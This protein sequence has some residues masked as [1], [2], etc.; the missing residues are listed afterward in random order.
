[1]KSPKIIVALGVSHR[2][3]DLAALWLRWVNF[4]CTQTDGDNR[5]NVLLIVHTK[6]AA[7]KMALVTSSLV[8]VCTGEFLTAV[9]ECPDE[10]ES[11]YPKSASHLFLRTLEI[12]EARWPGAAVFWAEPDTVPMRPTWF[13]EIAAEYESCGR[14]FLGMKVGTQFPHLSGNAVYPG[15]WREVAPSIANVLNAPDYRMWGPGKGQPW[16][17]Y[18]RGETTPQMAES[19]IMF[20][21]WKER[22]PRPTRLKDI[23][24]RAAFFHQ[25]KA[26]ALIREIAASRYPEFMAELVEPRRFFLMNGHPS[27]LRAKGLKIPFTFTK[28]T[29]AGHRSA[30]CSDELDDGQASSLAALVGQL[31]IREISEAEFLKITGRTARTL[32]E[33]K[34]RSLVRAPAPAE[35]R[36]SV[37]VML[38]R[39]G[40]ICNILP[41]LKA[42]ADAGRRPTLVVSQD[43]ADIL[44]GVSYVDRIVWDGGYDRLPDALRWLRREKGIT[45]AIVCQFHRNPYDKG[46]LTD[47][48]QKEV[49]RLAGRLG[50]FEGRGT[51]VFDNRDAGRESEF[52]KMWAPV[53]KP[54]ILVGLESISSP[55]ASSRAVFSEIVHAFQATHEIVDLS[56]VHAPR[57][58][59][60]I[61]LYEKAAV[62]VSTDTI[63]LHL[64]RG[65]DT[66]VIA[67]INDGWRGS[68]PNS[69]A[70]SVIRYNA[71]TPEKVVEAIRAAATSPL[72]SVRELATI[73]QKGREVFGPKIYHVVDIF[74]GDGLKK[75]QATWP[76]AY[77]EGITPVP[78]H[79]Y[80]RDA[81][82]EL[83]DPRG[84]PFLKDILWTGI[85]ADSTDRGED[86]ILWTNSDIGLA[87]GLAAL[88][89]D[90]VGKHGA[91]S[92]RRTESDGDG[93]PGRDLFA[94]TVDWLHA[95][96]DEIPDYVIGAPV[97]DLGLVAIIRKFHELPFTLAMMDDDLHPAEMHPGF[98]LHESHEPAWKLPN[99]D[100]IPSV[101]HNKKLFREWAKKH[102][103]EIRFSKGGNL[104]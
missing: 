68:V 72:I 51:L 70:T 59:D 13:K 79:G 23:P 32:P 81:K 7:E 73:V 27:R 15:N 75:A 30:V 61:A 57:V 98:A 33:P 78:I 67:I 26:G 95:H 2:D 34:I 39:F 71:A 42:E 93:H 102:A 54:I 8:G 28:W 53:S 52:L 65:V 6:R 91:A 87:P 56:D 17:V 29:V 85:P 94:F 92:M 4:L 19:N 63:H 90:H 22:D 84:L 21:V 103:P 25:D 10:D 89:R 40:D 86:I 16:D 60:M 55:F 101:I 99:M 64:T 66:R 77:A 82:G 11:G 104:L 38:G 24:K 9:V 74:Q 43:F 76:A 48:Y 36:S 83:G 97:F 1:M 80:A 69:N 41:M 20:Q 46:R 45:D 44:D 96:W 49:W 50:Q 3:A 37:F 88:L 100:S 58:Y 35:T 62:V 47:S 31:G 14:P 18:C 12:A 5:E